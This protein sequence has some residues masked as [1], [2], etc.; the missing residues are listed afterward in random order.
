MG[1]SFAGEASV[2]KVAP[3]LIYLNARPEGPSMDY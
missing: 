2:S 1:S 3:T